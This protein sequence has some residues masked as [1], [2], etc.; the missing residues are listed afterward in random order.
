MCRKHDEPTFNSMESLT[1][2]RVRL[3]IEVAYPLN[4][5]DDALAAL[6]DEI[7][8]VHALGF[9]YEVVFDQGTPDVT[10]NFFEEAGWSAA[11][12]TAG[13]ADPD[14]RIIKA[15]TGHAADQDDGEGTP[16]P[17][18]RLLVQLDKTQTDFYPAQAFRR[19]RRGAGHRR[20]RRV[21]G[22]RVR[23]VLMPHLELQG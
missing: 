15:P 10:F 17:P 9:E 2:G 18:S 8:R 4:S 16:A 11:E 22:R 7:G 5:T 23:R 12:R 13:S 21:L 6:A 3:L 1:D 19:P 14:S 20:R